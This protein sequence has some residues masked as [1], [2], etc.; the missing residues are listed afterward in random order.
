MTHYISD[1]YNDDKYNQLFVIMIIQI[2]SCIV[3][4]IALSIFYLSKSFQTNNGINIAF[5][6]LFFPMIF[7][8]I[9]W[10]II[11][12]KKD[13]KDNELTGLNYA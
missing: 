11:N 9:I 10:V 4:L 12:K 1:I 2:V 3:Y 5:T 13:L 8:M 7:R 6:V